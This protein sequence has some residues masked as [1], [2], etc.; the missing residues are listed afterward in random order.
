MFFLSMYIV[1][2]YCCTGGNYRVAMVKRDN[3]CKTLVKPNNP[4]MDYNTKYVI[5]IDTDM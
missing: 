2:H 4:I 5:D 1:L 3:K